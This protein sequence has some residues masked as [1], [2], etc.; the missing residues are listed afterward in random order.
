[1]RPYVRAFPNTFPTAI[2][3]CQQE[4]LDLKSLQQRAL[5]ALEVQQKLLSSNLKAS[6][7]PQ[8]SDGVCPTLEQYHDTATKS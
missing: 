6:A 2:M 1:M 5:R 3:S 7:N 4:A 8:P